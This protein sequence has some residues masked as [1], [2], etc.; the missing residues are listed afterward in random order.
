MGACA[1]TSPVDGFRVMR[2][3]STPR[4]STCLLSPTA[5]AVATGP[6]IG[7]HS[8]Y[9]WRHS[10]A[11]PAVARW[12]GQLV[13][14]LAVLK[15]CCGGNSGGVSRIGDL[16]GGE[17]AVILGDEQ[18]PVRAGQHHT[19]RVVAWRRNRRIAVD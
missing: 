19:T 1:A 3:P 9:V 6:G 4:A 10:G 2:E 17:L 16:L 13:G 18:G 7:R 15:A 14:A 11:S 5:A 8:R 12:C